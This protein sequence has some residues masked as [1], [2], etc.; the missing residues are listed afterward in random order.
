MNTHLN[1]TSELIV[2]PSNSLVKEIYSYMKLALQNYRTR[3]HLS[4]LPEY[5]LKDIG[6]TRAQARREAR[7]SFW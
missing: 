2:K 4:E 3:R 7:K 1:A 6:V 5:L